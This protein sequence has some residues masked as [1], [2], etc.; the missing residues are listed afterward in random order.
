MIHHAPGGADAPTVAN[1]KLKEAI[2]TRHVIAMLLIGLPVPFTLSG[3]VGPTVAA[4]GAIGGAV[5]MAGIT[6]PQAAELARAHCAKYGRSARI[7]AVRSDD[8]DK[9]V[10]ECIQPR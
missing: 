7:L 10:F 8:G 3:C 4:G 9:A 5:P 1:E 6:R 2:M